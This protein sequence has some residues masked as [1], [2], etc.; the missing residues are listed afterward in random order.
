MK[1]K[2]KPFENAI[3]IT[4]IANIHCFDFA[5]QLHTQKVPLFRK[6]IYN[7]VGYFTVRA[8]DQLFWKL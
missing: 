8:K 2:L 4:H 3:Q 7:D 1:F 5:K 6:L